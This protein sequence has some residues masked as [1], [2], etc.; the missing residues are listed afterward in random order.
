M[1]VSGNEERFLSTEQEERNRR[2]FEAWL[3]K[4]QDERKVSQSHLSNGAKKHT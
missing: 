1:A 3:L 4:K 2:A